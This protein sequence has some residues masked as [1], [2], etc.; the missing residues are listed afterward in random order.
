MFGDK[1]PLFYSNPLLRVNRG[2]VVE[3]NIRVNYTDKL[4]FCQRVCITLASEGWGNGNPE[5]IAKMK[6]GW[7][8]I[9]KDYAKFTNDYRAEYKSLREASE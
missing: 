2:G 3:D 9:M 4:T 6:V 1:Y 8:F 5:E 7:V